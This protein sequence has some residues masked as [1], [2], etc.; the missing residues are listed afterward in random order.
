MLTAVSDAIR[1]ALRLLGFPRVWGH[2]VWWDLAG[3]GAL[4][5]SR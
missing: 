1:E 5:L 2:L 3:G 4:G